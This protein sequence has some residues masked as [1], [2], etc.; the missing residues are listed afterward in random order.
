MKVL[1][2]YE[3]I[4]ASYLSRFHGEK[5][6]A[7]Y[8]QWFPIFPSER[9]AGII[10]DLMGDGHLQEGKLR[11][12]YTSKH[13]EELERFNREIKLLFG[14]SGKIRLN[15]T[16]KYGTMNLGVNNKPLG[17]VLQ[18]IGVP[19]GAKVFKSFLIPAWILENKVF[20]SRF[21]NRLYSCEA[22]VD[23]QS[24]CIDLHMSKHEA[25]LEEHTLFFYQIKENLFSHFNIEC[26]NPFLSGT[27]KRKDGRLTRGMHM[28]IKKNESLRIFQKYIGFEDAI[29]A[30]KLKVICQDI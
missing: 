20:F 26:T 28:K 13:R 12:D 14:V 5:A 24:K 2:T 16:N 21:I 1:A 11:L 10:A 25:L 30:E 27:N 18:H 7:P 3:D 4:L 6:L 17:R 9:L 8:K 22:C 19:T 29:K 15:V 23:V